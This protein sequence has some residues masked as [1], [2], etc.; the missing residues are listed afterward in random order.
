MSSQFPM[1][2][3]RARERERERE[4]GR[5]TAWWMERRW[6]IGWH[7]ALGYISPL[8]L[9]GNW[10]LIIHPAPN[11]HTHTPPQAQTQPRLQTQVCRSVM[12][13]F[14]LRWHQW[15]F[16][17]TWYHSQDKTWPEGGKTLFTYLVV[18]Q[19]SLR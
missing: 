12:Y 14:I 2:W 11:P 8:T 10:A 18:L 7:E 17:L 5:N 13:L 16:W 15:Q 3:C 1:Y 6:L 19:T 9:V 4:E